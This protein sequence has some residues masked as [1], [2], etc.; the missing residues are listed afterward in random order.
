MLKKHCHK[1]LNQEVLLFFCAVVC[2]LRRYLVDAAAAAA[3]VAVC[4]HCIAR[5]LPL[6]IAQSLKKVGTE[7]WGVSGGFTVACRNG[8]KTEYDNAYLF[9]YF[10]CL[11]LANC[12]L[13]RINGCRAR[14][15]F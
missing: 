4:S 14:D 15:N 11:P 9:V 12:I 7:G 1:V 10:C 13:F 5:S 6:P 8:P 3:S 2:M